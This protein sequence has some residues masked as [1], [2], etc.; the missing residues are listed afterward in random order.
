MSRL[1]TQFAGLVFMVILALLLWFA[2]AVY[3]KRFTPVSTVMLRTDRIGN[4]M[5]L[6]AEVKARGVPFGTVRAVRT[7]GDGAEIEL[8]MDTAR[9]GRLPSNVSARLVPKT[10]FGERYV[11]LVLPAEPD[12]RALAAG[13]T[14]TQDRSE[15][16]IE[17]ERV[18]GDVLPLLR[19]VQ[20]EKLAASL[21]SISMALDGRGEPLGESVRQ[22]N[23]LLAQV[24]PLMPRLRADISG[25]ADVADVY[26]RAAPDVLRA[27]ADLSV[28]GRTIAEQR[29]ELD[30]LYSDVTSTSVGLTEF[31]R[32][33]GENFIGVSESSRPTLELLARYS[34][35][36]PCLFDA[37]N[38]F[39]PLMV[40][41]LGKGTNE[42][43]LHVELT[44]QPPRG[45]YRP[46]ADDPVY[47]A[48]GGPRCYPPGAGPAGGVATSS[49]PVAGSEYET[50]LISE[51]LAPGMG[52][53]PREVPAWNGL[54]VGPLLRG[55]EVTLR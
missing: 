40:E 19:A 37:V 20:P 1:A 14:I 8:A 39:T 25:L 12:R 5:E 7:S 13:D 6:N 4:Q 26:Q 48:T 24:N 30:A 53:H 10:L 44:V 21:G 15:N 38:R 33:N 9:I 46:G 54:L 17:L 45:K 16:A 51:L 32:Q 35:E 36:Y 2:V 42:P 52:V 29:S 3:E 18:L 50:R 47:D 28:T 34:P 23:D 49:A 31:L 43:G 27:L 22:L 41:A 11:D 55:A